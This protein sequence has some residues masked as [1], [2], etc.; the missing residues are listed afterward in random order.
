V[1]PDASA[2]ANVVD[3]F[4]LEMAYLGEREW[5]VGL[6]AVGQRAMQVDMA[7]PGRHT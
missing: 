4:R 6:D 3:T 5:I 1:C 7:L 2:L